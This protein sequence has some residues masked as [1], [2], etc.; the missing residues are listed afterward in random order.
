M[1]SNAKMSGGLF[2]I[3][4]K[5][6]WWGA[7]AKRVLQRGRLPKHIAFV[8]DGNRR[9]ARSHRM[10]SVVDGHA[11]GF[12]QIAKV[13]YWCREFG[14]T[15]VTVY[16]F[17]IENFKRSKEEVHGLMKM[18]EKQLAKLL[19]ESQ[20]LS[21]SD[22]RFQFYGDLTLL[23]RRLQ[24][25]MAKLELVTENHT[26]GTLNICFAY[27]SQDE[28]KRAMQ[29]IQKGIHKGPLEESDID[30]WLINKCLDSRNSTNV[31]MLIRTSECR[32]SDFLLWQCSHSYVHFEDVLWPDFD[33]W[34]LIKALSGYQSNIVQ[35]E[36]IKTV[37]E[38]HIPSPNLRKYAF[39]EWMDTERLKHLRTLADE[40][41]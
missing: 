40:L 18:A 24:Q 4:K 30:Q 8:M 41:S 22:I 5:L 10:A 12:E 19:R 2:D 6:P 17:S 25:L 1:S 37:H 33:F 3:P 38:E 7:V 34:H 28:M 36:K 26:K 39:V 21:D 14:V 35:V 20:K 11:R 16:A 31:E 29:L 23:P 32:L 27:T 13:L 9:Y 15:E